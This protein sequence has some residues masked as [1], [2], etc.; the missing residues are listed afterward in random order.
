M[1]RALFRFSAGFLVLAP[2]VASAHPGYEGASL[3]HAFLHA[4]DQ[5]IAAFGIGLMAAHLG[6]WALWGLC[7]RVLSPR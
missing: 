5:F 7:R 6:G 2:T 3:V 4:P 1:H